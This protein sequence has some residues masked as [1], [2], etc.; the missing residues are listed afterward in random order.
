M[1]QD[2]ASSFGTIAEDYDRW[3]PGPNPAVVDWL[4]PEGAQRVVDLGAGTGALSRLLVGRVPDLV[5]VEPDARMREVLARNVPEVTVLEGR[6]EQLPLPDSSRD[7]V[8]VSSAW[9]WMDADA[10]V[11][12][13]ARVLRPGGVLG[14]AW[15]GVD[16][17]SDWF[18]QLRK[19]V[20]QDRLEQGPG[21]LGLLVKPDARRERRLFRLPDGAPFE[22]PERTRVHWTETLS[23]DH[24]VRM[25]GTFS[26]VI[27]LPDDQ[28]RAV[29]D[30][31]RDVLR[32]YAGLE[33]DAPVELA[34]GA[35]CWRAVRTR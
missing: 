20:P 10:T 26:Q 9:H 29:L 22:A 32:R 31:A 35:A 17:D 16:W 7:A 28:R 33:G 19:A 4:L 3:R 23:A 5:A 18:T 8:L 24:L 34:F 25:F 21:L 1:S 12:E 11:T 14:V 6:G 13:V 30:E 15:A 2:K 27:V